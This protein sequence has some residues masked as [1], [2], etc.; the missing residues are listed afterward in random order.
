MLVGSAP[1]HVSM[2]V[3]SAPLNAMSLVGILP[4]TPRFATCA[5]NGRGSA[6]GWSQPQ[7]HCN[8]CHSNPTSTCNIQA[9]QDPYVRS[10]K[11]KVQLIAMAIS[12]CQWRECA[13][14]PTMGKGSAT[15]FQAWTQDLMLR[16][17]SSDAELHQ[18]CALVIS[19]LGGAAHEVACTFT[20]A[21]VWQGGMVNGEQLDAVSI[22]KVRS[23]FR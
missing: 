2:S 17:I 9:A 21:E 16:A 14:S 6:S 20:P 7:Q 10:S 22:S 13:S 1:H 11:A 5:T 23:P 3:G 19:Q 8:K 15:S 4:H 12:R 18:H